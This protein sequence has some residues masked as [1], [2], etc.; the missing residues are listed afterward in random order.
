[1]RPTYLLTAAVILTALVV[2]PARARAA[3]AAPTPNPREQWLVQARAADAI[4][5]VLMAA[6]ER[7]EEQV[8]LLRRTLANAG[9]KQAAAPAA[10]GG[11]PA[12]RD[13]Q[14]AYRALFDHVAAEVRR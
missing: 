1:M 5:E 8:A 10:P 6:S 11:A 2:P 9:E 12:A 7:A 14:A 4:G 3:A 13:P